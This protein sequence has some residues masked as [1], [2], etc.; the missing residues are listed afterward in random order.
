MVGRQTT[1]GIYKK[2]WNTFR[3]KPA[4]IAVLHDDPAAR[5][6]AWLRLRP[7]RLTAKDLSYRA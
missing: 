3:I 2:G 6:T 4:V 1:L 5:G 7:A